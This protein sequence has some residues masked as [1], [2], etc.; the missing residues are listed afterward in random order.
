MHNLKSSGQSFQKLSCASSRQTDGHSLID[1]ESSKAY[2][3]QRRGHTF[4]S[5]YQM[6]YSFV[7]KVE[8]IKDTY[9]FVRIVKVQYFIDEILSLF[10][11]NFSIDVIPETF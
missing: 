10:V 3:S 5:S 2:L 8:R 1:L 9:K 4:G 6:A 7:E 11:K